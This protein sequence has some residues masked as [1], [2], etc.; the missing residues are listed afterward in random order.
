MNDY[1]VGDVVDGIVTSIKKYGAFLS[2]E[3]CFIGLLHISEI[4]SHFIN[5]IFN[6]VHVGDKI[7][8]VVKKVDSVNKYLSVSVKDLPKVDQTFVN[9]ETSKDTV[10]L[11][12]VDFTKLEKSLPNMV[13]KEL[14]KEKKV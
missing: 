1:K 2:F 14:Q 8:V 12:E 6:Y 5:N 7:K 4:S 10:Y 13:E 11:Q 3:N 9:N